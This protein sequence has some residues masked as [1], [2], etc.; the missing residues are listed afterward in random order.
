[1]LH[2]TK[3]GSD[4]CLP[5]ARIQCPFFPL[6]LTGIDIR[7]RFISTVREQQGLLVRFFQ[8]CG[9]GET[10]VEWDIKLTRA[11]ENGECI[12]PEAVAIFPLLTGYFDDDVDFFFKLCEVSR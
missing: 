11:K 9:R 7:G 12:A 8:H 2:V 6:R 5:K 3:K 10:V 4:V 1:M